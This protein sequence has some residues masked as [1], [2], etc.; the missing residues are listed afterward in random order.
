M[1]GLAISK[2]ARQ[3]RRMLRALLSNSF[4]D[5]DAA[6]SGHGVANILE[7]AAHW[8]KQRAVIEGMARESGRI[9][10]E[11]CDIMINSLR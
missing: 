5:M 11:A 7:P 4:G 8:L 6:G 1:T 9:K 2:L 10:H 3:E